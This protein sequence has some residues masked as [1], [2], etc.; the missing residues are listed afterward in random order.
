VCGTVAVRDW[1]CHG[2]AAVALAAHFATTYT[3]ADG[4]RHIHGANL[5]V[6]AR[7]YSRAGG[8]PP[9]PCHED[10]ALVHALEQTGARIAWSARPRV[11]TSARSA[12]RARGGFGDALRAA[13]P[14]A[15]ARLGGSGGTR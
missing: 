4:H 9:L 7:A 10:V 12:T 2:S 13:T 15:L 11:V 6:C 8:F 3:D 1:S 14:L 5:G